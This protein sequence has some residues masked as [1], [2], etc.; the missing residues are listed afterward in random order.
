MRRA[1]RRLQSEP[2]ARK[3]DVDHVEECE[4]RLSMLELQERVVCVCA[5]SDRRMQMRAGLRMR[6]ALWVQRMRVLQPRA[7]SR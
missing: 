2:S 7:L 3:E 1:P 5:A 4:R 6:Q